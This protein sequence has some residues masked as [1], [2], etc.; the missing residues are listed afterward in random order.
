MKKGLRRL[1]IVLGVIVALIVAA[2]LATEPVLNSSKV[3]EKIYSAANAAVP[4]GSVDWSRLHIS[5]VRSFPHVAVEVDSVSVTYPHELFSRYDGLGVRSPLLGEGRGSEVDTLL[6]ARGLSASLNVLQL[7]KGTIRV[8]HVSL[9]QPRVFFHSYTPE[10][11]N[12]AIFGPSEPDTLDKK[13]LNLPWIS[14]GK[15]S[16]DSNPYLV[17]T[18]QA[19]TVFANAVFDSMTL[20]G[21]VLLKGDIGDYKVQKLRFCLD[22][23][24]AEG[25]L[26]GDTFRLAVDR[27]QIEN[28]STNVLDLGLGGNLL[29][30]SA[31]VGKLNIPAK[32]EAR[33]GFG[34]SGDGLELDLHRLD[35]EVA[36]IPLH[37]EGKYIMYDDHGKVNAK[38]S[39]NDCDLG[40]VFNEYARNFSR[41]AAR[42]RPAGR[43]SLSASADG[44]ISDKEMPET[45]ASVNMDMAV[46][47]LQLKL[48]G[49]AKDLLG[50]NLL[51]AARA[52]MGVVLDSIYKYMPDDLDLKGNGRVNLTADAK[53]YFKELADYKFE[54]SRLKA[55]LNGD[56]VAVSMP[57]MD[58]EAFLLA[59]DVKLGNSSNSVLLS[60][61]V[62]ST[63]VMLGEGT[64]TVLKNFESKAEINKKEVDGALVPYMRLDSSS[65]RIRLRSG[66]NRLGLNGIDLSV[67]ASRRVRNR[68][69]RQPDNARRAA[70]DSLRKLYPGAGRDSLL[71]II[72]GARPVDEF[73]SRDIKVA[74]DSSLL[75][76]YDK[77]RPGG[78][79]SIDGGYFRSPA[80]PLRTRISSVDVA[81]DDDDVQVAS[82]GVKCGS[83]DMALTGYVGNIRPF[84]RGRRPLEFDLDLHSNRLNL[85]EILVAT[86]EA[87]NSGETVSTEN[88]DYVREDLEDATYVR[89]SVM[90]AIVV[91]KNLAGSVRLEADKVDY[92]DKDFTDATAEINVR[93]RVLQ[94]K[95]V[96]VDSEMGQIKMDAF[97]ATHSRD[98]IN[99]GLDMHLI[100]MSAYD[101]IHMVPSVDAMMPALK[102]FEGKLG[103]DVSLTTQLDT[104][105]NILMPSLNGLVRI[106]GRDLHVS[107]AGDLRKI[108]RLL[109]FK[110]KNI[111]DIDDLNVDAVIS[112]SRLEV[113]PFELGVDRYRLALMGTH[114]FNGNMKY[115]VSILK[116][117]LPI[118]FGVNIYGSPEKIR[119]S[120]GR[121]KYKDGKVPSFTADIDTMQVNV[122]DAIRNIYENGVDAAMSQ[123]EKEQARLDNVKQSG[124]YS[125]AESEILTREEFNEL[126][127]MM[128]EMN[129]EED[130]EAAE[131]EI[132]STLDAALDELSEEQK[133]WAAE[134]PWAELAESRAEKRRAAKGSK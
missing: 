32:L 119:F 91:P 127:R 133:K 101:I 83:S 17:Y 114:S 45:A 81:I 58:V 99:A 134:H 118:P 126:D 75:A 76:L 54:K 59:P 115:H 15:A 82:M 22:N 103:C 62:D 93:D 108:T 124:G 41:E 121:C 34:K 105:M 80:L 116:S 21:D 48:D 46:D 125:G 107:N 31:S 60:L 29:F 12:I 47:G 109:M 89:D 38:A 117:I 25:R 18:S 70:L 113:F 92:S 43:L 122:L 6:S 69:R 86:Q 26:P 27:M 73:S 57:S 84:I 3:Q 129:M 7:I 128:F 95:D 49:D 100:N 19:N 77:W 20:S 23:L 33:A 13:P 68:S 67:D 94:V 66:E 24:K 110:D 9:Q 35:G 85:N 4:D 11:S 78:L 96:G 111:G 79:L 51:V 74:L 132:S 104:N 50:D 72:R 16:I 102:S 42:I 1:C 56:R 71:G 37:A 63:S 90:R 120:L 8:S 65:D 30:S 52:D 39:I 123:M 44:N 55:D 88:E 106:S 53:L 10:L 112:D 14:V 28:H 5:T 131:K 98:D 64:R 36:Y 61:G 40:R 2:V 97:Y 130:L 87:F